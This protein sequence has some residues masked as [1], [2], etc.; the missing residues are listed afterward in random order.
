M[1]STY[2][3]I[4]VI[5]VIL[6]AVMLLFYLNINPFKIIKIK[7]KKEQ[8]IIGRADIPESRIDSALMDDMAKSK[9][10]TLEA[11]KALEDYKKSHE[12]NVKVNINQEIKKK[13]FKEKL[14]IVTNGNH[15][16]LYSTSGRENYQVIGEQTVFGKFI[17]LIRYQHSSNI[18]VYYQ[19]K[20]GSPQLL[21][22]RPFKDLIKN[23]DK[24]SKSVFVRFDKQKR[25]VPESII[26]I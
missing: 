8:V 7:K 19:D 24:E 14:D 3:I 10:E 5:L 26:H 9:Q 2:I 11:K 21:G 1:A 20:K 16:P 12:K 22:P 25:Y 15:L 17:S 18:Y 23:I 6:L 13:E 4:S